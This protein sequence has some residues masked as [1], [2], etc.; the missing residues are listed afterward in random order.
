MRENVW[1]NQWVVLFYD[2]FGAHLVSD[3]MKFLAEQKIAVMALPAHS[4]DK[5]QPLEIYFFI[6]SSNILTLLQ[7]IL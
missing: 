7:N 2:G 4:S 3:V 5:I 1:Q 6:L